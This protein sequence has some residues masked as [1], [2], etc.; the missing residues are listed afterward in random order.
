MTI[1]IT[2]CDIEHLFL[3]CV[4]LLALDLAISGL[5]QHVRGPGK[6]PVAAFFLPLRW[7]PKVGFIGESVLLPSAL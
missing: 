7:L 2:L 3:A 6:Q 4:A 1:A 5:G